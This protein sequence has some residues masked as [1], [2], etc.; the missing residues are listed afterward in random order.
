MSL[1]SIC[2]GG[3]LGAILRHLI[4]KFI[5]GKIDHFFPFGTLMVNLFGMF[6][7]GFS[8]KIFDNYFIPE[9]FEKFLIT[10]FLG[11][12][13]TFSS[14]ALQTLLLFDKKRYKSGITNIFLNNFLGM[15]VAIFGIFVGSIF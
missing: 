1:I 12:L 10:G 3:F 5:T 8:Y 9:S 6:I 4:N 14:Y 7:I 15:L 11:A 2:L 13:T